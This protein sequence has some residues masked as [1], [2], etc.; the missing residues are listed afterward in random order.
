MEN[1]FMHKKRFIKMFIGF[2]V[3]S[4]ANHYAEEHGLIPISISLT[5]TD[6]RYIDQIAVIFEVDEERQPK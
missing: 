5:D 4:E 1:R 2:D 3:Y 6:N